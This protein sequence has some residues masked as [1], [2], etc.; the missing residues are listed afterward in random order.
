MD[1]DGDGDAEEGIGEEYAAAQEKQRGHYASM[2]R[3]WPKPT[4]SMMRA[5]YPYWFGDAIANGTKDDDEKGYAK[6]TLRLL[7]AAY[8]Y[9]A[10]G[11]DPCVRT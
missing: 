2:P 6:L 4:S 8:N 7:K 10:A 5:L 3:K 9:Q 1:Y 11:K